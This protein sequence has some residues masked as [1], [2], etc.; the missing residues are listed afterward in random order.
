[1]ADSFDCRTFFATVGLNS[2]SEDQ[3]FK[4][5]RVLDHSES[6]FIEEEELSI[7]LK[8][9]SDSARALTEAEVKAFLEAGDYDG[10][11]KIGLD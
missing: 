3:L 2:K 9:F 11:G 7:F 6:G 5:F 4:I 8:H 10:D 1:A